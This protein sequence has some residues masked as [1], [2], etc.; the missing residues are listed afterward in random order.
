MEKA[1]AAQGKR[2]GGICRRVVAETMQQ[3][4]ITQVESGC[5]I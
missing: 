1:T 4:E 5:T 3:D 2:F